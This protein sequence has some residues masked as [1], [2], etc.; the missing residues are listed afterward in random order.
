MYNLTPNS[1]TTSNT[2][3]CILFY[4]AK[5]QVRQKKLQ[6]LI[7]QALP[8]SHKSWDYEKVKSITY[9]DDIINEA[10]RLKPPVLNIPPRETPPKGI[11]IGDVYI[12][13]NIN[14]MVPL[15]L[16][17]RDPRWWKEANDFIPERWGERREEMG[18]AEAPFFPFGLGEYHHL[19]HS[20]RE[21]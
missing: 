6:A 2:L 11:Q 13:G 19:I 7:D 15:V 16:I 14:V 10:L 18:T 17:Q 4:L 20:L 9:I 1:D 8:G 5:D 21:L 3:A 12:P